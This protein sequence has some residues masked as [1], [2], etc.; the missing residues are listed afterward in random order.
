MIYLMVENISGSVIRSQVLSALI[1]ITQHFDLEVDLLAMERR[2]VWEQTDNLNALRR[3][4]D[5]HRVSL[6]VFAL[7]EMPPNDVYQFDQHALEA[8]WPAYRE[9]APGDRGPQFPCRVSGDSTAYAF[10][11]ESFDPGSAR[12]FCSRACS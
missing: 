2:A 12:G 7:W 4:L 11:Q 1:E 5:V 10:P 3:E 8:A 9:R 6:H